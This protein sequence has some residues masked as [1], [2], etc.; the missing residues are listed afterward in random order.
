M[1]K[2]ALTSVI[3]ISGMITVGLFSSQI[4]A[5]WLDDLKKAKKTI[6]EV[7]KAAKDVYDPKNKNSKADKA[8]K[9]L[10]NEIPS[11]KKIVFDSEIKSQTTSSDNNQS[12]SNSK[13]SKSSKN[14]KKSK[15]NSNNGRDSNIVNLV[16]NGAYRGQAQTLGQGRLLNRDKTPITDNNKGL[17]P[18]QRIYA[19]IYIKYYPEVLDDDSMVESLSHIFYSSEV[20]KFLSSAPNV[21]EK[22]RKI[23]EWR[24][25]IKNID[26]VS[27]KTFQYYFPIIF[28]SR[29]NFKKQS[30]NIGVHFPYEVNI[31]SGVAGLSCIELNQEFRLNELKIPES[32][33]EA[34]LKRNQSNIRTSSIFVGLRFNITGK[35]KKKGAK[36]P[37][38]QLAAHVEAI[39]GFEYRSKEKNQPSSYTAQVGKKI[40]SWTVENPGTATVSLNLQHRKM[41]SNIPQVAKDFKLVTRQGHI[42]YLNQTTA[43]NFSQPERQAFNEYTDFLQLGINPDSLKLN[44]KCYA[45]TYLEQKTLNKYMDKKGNRWNGATSFEQDRN[46]EAFLKTEGAKLLQRSVKT[47]QKFIIVS[48]V[49]LLKYDKKLSGFRISQLQSGSSFNEMYPPCYGYKIKINNMADQLPDFWKID[50]TSAETMLNSLPDFDKKYQRHFVYL[51]SVVELTSINSAKLDENSRYFPNP[52]IKLTVE[53]ATLYADSDL[54]RE[55]AAFDINRSKLSII[56]TG[57]SKSM[58][59][60]M[61]FPMSPNDYMFLALKNQGDVLSE[62]SWVKLSDHQ[63]V[64]DNYYYMNLYN[65]SRVS[66]PENA[67]LFTAGLAKSHTPFFPK[68]VDIHYSKMSET[69]KQLFKKWSM[70]RAKNL[71]STVSYQAQ[72]TWNKDK[73]SSIFNVG[74]SGKNILL[75][76]VIKDLGYSKDQIF[77]ASGGDRYGNPPTVRT[78]KGNFTVVYALPKALQSYAKL[79]ASQLA[80]VSKKMNNTSGSGNV[81]IEFKF[82]KIS[83]L[84]DKNNSQYLLVQATPNEFS[85]FDYYW[86]NVVLRKKL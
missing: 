65:Q 72:I 32:E 58:T 21:F 38:C 46:K 37:R 51:A 18:P 84:T 57:I 76:D 81:R 30:F 19:L 7:K 20:R 67:T 49:P 53:S 68:Q 6:K 77:Y 44:T 61:N 55:L 26:E 11:N 13:V 54:K 42:V 66:M 45:K 80:A 62:D 52:P 35:T 34:F 83:F 50:Q 9:E 60:E 28:D 39:E 75:P 59:K 24:E 31:S 63:R 71:P 10:A 78:L 16:A 22:R 74:R 73:G 82:D 3:L 64:M 86:R 2:K 4:Q 27:P 12:T 1:V 25:R 17:L 8:S 23:N 79:N 15:K 40:K 85:V 33:A 48:K 5:N 70:A 47:P 43:I 29:Y 69:Q 41:P 14:N 36:R 56:E